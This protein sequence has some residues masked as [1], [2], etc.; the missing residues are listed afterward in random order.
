MQYLKHVHHRH[1]ITNSSSL[2]RSRS[3][4]FSFITQEKAHAIR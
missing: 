1:S 3:G 4:Q 2:D